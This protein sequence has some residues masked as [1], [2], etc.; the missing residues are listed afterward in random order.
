LSADLETEA[1]IPVQ[2]FLQ[3]ELPDYMVPSYFI[4][5]AKFTIN[6]NGKV[7]RKAL[8]LTDQ[9]IITGVA[10]KEAETD[11]Q[12]RIAAA[13]RKTL[14]L[15]K[16]S[17]EDDFFDLGGHSLKA[18]SLVAELQKDFEV[19]V[20]H[21]FEYRTAKKLSENIIEK[22]TNIGEKLSHIS[23]IMDKQAQRVKEYISSET[24]QKRVNEYRTSFVRYEHLHPDERQGYKHILLTGT[25][26]YLGV[27]L[28]DELL[29]TTQ[30]HI[31]ALVR[32]KDQD[33]S[34]NR[35]IR[36][37]EY[38]FGKNYIN[39]YRDRITV[40]N[41]DL[42]TVQLGLDDKFYKYAAQNVDAIFHP[43]ALVKH[44]GDLSV[45]RKSN[46][47]AV[48][49]LIDF[50]L[51]HKSKDLHHVSTLSV[52][53]GEVEGAHNVMYTE[54]DYDQGQRS[55]NYYAQTKFEAEKLV[56]DARSK[57]IK[58]N[59][60]RI[61]NVSV[62][63]KTGHLQSDVEGNAFY[64][65]LKGYANIGAIP[66]AFN[67]VEFA[68]VNELAA[69]IVNLGTHK[70]LYN[71]NWHLWNT[72]K[73]ELADVLTDTAL[74]LN[75]EKLGFDA[76]IAYLSKHYD[77]DVFKPHI[78]K[79]L[80]HMGWLGL[81]SAPPDEVLSHIT[82]EHILSERT[83]YVLE[84]LGF[85]WPKTDASLIQKMLIHALG[86]RLMFMKQSPMFVNM[87]ETLLEK[88]APIM[89]R[90]Y[91]ENG[92]DVHW[93]KD[94]LA[95]LQ[96]IENGVIELSRHS[97]AGWVGTIG[98]LQQGEHLGI[99]SL[100]QDK[101][102]AAIAEAILGEL[103]LYEID[104]KKLLQIGQEHPEI[105]FRLLDLMIDRIRKLETM[106]VNLG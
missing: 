75:I 92:E 79:I 12:K 49:H 54:D 82:T 95:H 73:I 39:V 40:L 100:S 16:I 87:D 45:F 83:D 44:Y 103:T 47:E 57:G 74:N 28:L 46:V 70:E 102:A 71:S 50:A 17:M 65:V 51:D 80:L 93:E 72:H 68:W 25:T 84:K 35:L 64:S 61:G 89:R 60:Y 43:A 63:S 5:M 67:E 38:Y 91:F 14:G 94:C 18:V 106:I 7:D 3:K 29:Q 105:A 69:A 26:G 52:F 6:V 11:A 96:L 42:G 62:N 31:Y 76:F 88:L 10:F 81:L 23:Y 24:H 33:E 78:E 97:V 56:M 37:I 34:K 77:V 104:N 55:D 22:K 90:K 27:H 9:Q 41:G 32:G 19:S 1:S 21:I 48:G 13:F 15:E 86:E 2:K 4:S 8:P 98:V 99:E 30:A 53:T 101:Q 20:N 59:I 36:Q 58:T 85:I 66:D